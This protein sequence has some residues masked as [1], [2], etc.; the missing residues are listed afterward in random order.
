MVKPRDSVYGIEICEHGGKRERTKEGEVIDF[1]A[2]LNPYGP[3]DFV[4]DALKGAINEINAYPDTECSE[5]REKIS[6]KF[7]C[8]EE[9]VLV[10]AGASELIRLVALSFVKNR[11]LIAKHTYGEYE[12]AA[13]IVGAEIKRIEMPALQITPEPIVNSLKNDDVVF[14]CNPN[15]PTGQYLGKKE[16]EQILEEAERVD[17]LMVIDEAYA[18]FVSTAFPAHRCPLQ[19]LIILRSLTKSFAIPGIRLG[20]AISSEENI[21][22]LRKIK[23]PWSVSALAQRIGLTVTGAEGGDFLVK[24]KEKIERSKIK[25]EEAFSGEIQSDANFY[26]CELAK[27]NARDAK[28][29]LLEHGILVRDCA[30]FGLPS[31]I[32]F[33]V[34]REAENELLLNALRVSGVL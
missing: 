30:S 11:A 8:R 24:T 7:G 5:L 10:G 1:S 34:K 17:S 20:Y 22:A 27:K 3:P 29:A 28:K 33:S 26:I 32:R 18:D 6:K 15:N 13:K 21:R 9:E 31:Y 23:T 2:N 12:V 14:L 25:I 19:N 4:F 16:I